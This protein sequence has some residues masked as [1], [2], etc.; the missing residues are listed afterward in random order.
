MIVRLTGAIWFENINKGCRLISFTTRYSR[1]IITIT[2][3]ILGVGALIVRWITQN[4]VVN[5]VEIIISIALLEKWILYFLPK[6]IAIICCSCQIWI[7]FSC[8]II[9][10]VDER[11][12]CLAHI[13]FLRPE[14]VPVHI[15]YG[16]VRNYVVED[17]L[18]WKPDGIWH[19]IPV[20]ISCEIDPIIRIY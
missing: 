4:E 8:L 13:F 18:K 6:R 17:E 16:K 7:W 20:V 2:G 14:I 19:L 15:D 5:I 11:A 10:I 1:T 12:I 9:E 3:H